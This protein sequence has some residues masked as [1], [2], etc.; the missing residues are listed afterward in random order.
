MGV[1]TVLGMI[2]AGIVGLVGA[3]F[4]PRT[5]ACVLGGLLAQAYLHPAWWTL[6]G[7]LALIGFC[8]DWKLLDEVDNK[9][10]S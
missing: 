6:F 8:I 10:F 7:I 3:V 9:I 4:F 2:F 1:F 5:I